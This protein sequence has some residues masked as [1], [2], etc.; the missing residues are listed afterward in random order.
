MNKKEIERS[1]RE[2][3]ASDTKAH[4]D[5]K[6]R[7]ERIRVLWNLGKRQ[8]GEIETNPKAQKLRKFLKCA[9]EL[10]NGDD[11]VEL[12]ELVG[13]QDREIEYLTQ[14]RHRW[15]RIDAH[16][17]TELENL[18]SRAFFAEVKPLI[19]KMR[20]ERKPKQT[21]ERKRGYY[22]LGESGEIENGFANFAQ[23]SPEP[24]NFGLASYQ[25]LLGIYTSPVL[26]EIFAGGGVSMVKLQQLFGLNRNR[27]PASLPSFKKGRERLYD[28]G[29]VTKIM[30]AL[31][32][33]NTSDARAT[34][35]GRPS[36]SWA[37]DSAVRTH[38]FK[39]IESRMRAIAA[40]KHIATAFMRVFHRHRTDSAKK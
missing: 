10:T 38:V 32:S 22:R 25:R 21:Y 26:D 37:N 19:E 1:A 35:K 2:R 7:Q 14:F 15:E 16:Y 3:V 27:F 20:T 33:E 34:K 13:L 8:S 12:V 36:R 23:T 17:P 18:E 31:L 28:Y 40:P 11:L 29:A 5:S 9:S 30:D 39:G 24:F 6:D 4:A